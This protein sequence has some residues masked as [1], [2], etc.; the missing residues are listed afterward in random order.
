MWKIINTVDN[1]V[2]E[3]NKYEINENGKIRNYNSKKNYSCNDNGSGYK[4]IAL[5][6][7]NKKWKR[8]Y[9]HRIVYATFMGDNINNMVINHKNL[10]RSCNKLNN[11]ELCTQ[12]ENIYYSINKGTINNI[13]EN[14][15]NCK[16]LT[17]KK[18]KKI[19]KKLENNMSVRDICQS[20][21]ISYED[22]KDLIH[23]INSGK[24][25]THISKDYNL[26]NTKRKSMNSHKKYVEKVC[27]L[28]SK[29]I[30]N[31]TQIANILNIDISNI[32]EYQKFFNFI[33][34]IKNKKSYKD[35]SDR[36]F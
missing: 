21:D 6:L 14:G 20:L 19:C 18:V 30:T 26:K 29:D 22:Y 13:G 32:N 7:E 1:F 8:F 4:A 25:W 9:I 3:Q 24:L 2:I 33:K 27:Y 28:L 31:V 5:K 34:R 23:K 10:D 36:Y 35:I 17:E 12:K 15:N 16:K 11:L